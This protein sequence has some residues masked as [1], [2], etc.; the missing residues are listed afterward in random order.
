MRARLIT[1]P[2]LLLAD[3][4]TFLEYLEVACAI[5]AAVRTDTLLGFFRHGFG[6]CLKGCSAAG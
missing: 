1:T 6:R 2:A 3:R 5:R 4:L